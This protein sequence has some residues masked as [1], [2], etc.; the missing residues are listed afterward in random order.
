MPLN[1]KNFVSTLRKQSFAALLQ[2]MKIDFLSVKNK[3][4]LY[5]STQDYEVDTLLDLFPVDLT[6]ASSA[7]VNASV[8]IL[9]LDFYS[10]Y[11]CLFSLYNNYKGLVDVSSN[12]YL[13]IENLVKTL[14]STLNL[15]KISKENKYVTYID[16]ID[17]NFVSIYKSDILSRTDA[18]LQFLSFSNIISLPIVITKEMTPYSIVAINNDATN[19][20]KDII[21]YKDDTIYYN[22]VRPDNDFVGIVS[23]IKPARISTSRT[24]EISISGILTDVDM[25]FMYMKVTGV[26]DTNIDV[27]FSS[28]GSDWSS[29]IRAKLNEVKDLL[30]EEDINTGLTFS[31]KFDPSIKLEDTWIIKINKIQLPNP[32]TEFRIKFNNFDKIS[33]VTIDDISPYQLKNESL[34][35]KRKQ[36]QFEYSNIP[37][38]TNDNKVIAFPSD[39]IEEIKAA[40]TQEDSYFYNYNGQASYNYPFYLSNI[41]AVTNKYA[42][43]GSLSFNPIDAVEINNIYISSDEYI[44]CPTEGYIK[45]MFIEYNIYAEIDLD[46]T[47]IPCIKYND[48]EQYEY[49]LANSIDENNTITYITRMPVELPNGDENRIYLYNIKDEEYTEVLA[50]NQNEFLSYEVV[51]NDFVRIIIRNYNAEKQY[52]VKYTAKVYSNNDIYDLSDMQKWVKKN[53]IYYMYYKDIN[54]EFKTAIKVINSSNEVIPFT[55]T[56]SS[57]IEMR[58]AEQHY[59]SPYIMRYQLVCN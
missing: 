44:Y 25:S 45:K 28:N 31:V 50:E 42:Q 22:I 46:K 4:F 35:L 21:D 8:L 30:I 16:F 47:L 12:K 49:V 15:K 43:Q 11:V 38:F 41:K 34:L 13:Y 14:Q 40:Y 20:Y 52:A 55:G 26:S 27:Q 51:D 17:K 3:I 53:K 23:E 36:D 59:L 19:N 32:S 37:K 24:I 1:V 48:K 57:F 56:I 39:T 5:S 2:N 6:V 54:N 29:D 33:Y 9:Y 10:L 7:T 58:S 18:S